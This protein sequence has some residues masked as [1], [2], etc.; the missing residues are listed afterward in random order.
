MYKTLNL[1]AFLKE[2]HP[3]SHIKLSASVSSFTALAAY[4]A[5]IRFNIVLPYAFYWLRIDKYALPA[6][7][8]GEQGNGDKPE[9][10][11]KLESLDMCHS[12]HLCVCAPAD[13]EWTLR[14]HQFPS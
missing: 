1:D 5:E 11:T 3:C 6:A 8:D 10:Q 14:K 12:T 13:V 9:I 7:D 4:G 2:G